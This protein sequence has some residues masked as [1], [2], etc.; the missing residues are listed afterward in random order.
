MG[1]YMGANKA[2]STALYHHVPTTLVKISTDV[3]Y[4]AVSQTQPFTCQALMTMK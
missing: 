1:V 2:F 3:L 4:N